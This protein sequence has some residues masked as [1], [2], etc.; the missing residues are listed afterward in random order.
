[1]L[2]DI[3]SFGDGPRFEANSVIVGS[4]LKDLP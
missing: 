3:A 4:H 1:M 2:T